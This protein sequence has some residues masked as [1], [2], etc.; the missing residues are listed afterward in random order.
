MMTKNSSST[1]IDVLDKYGKLISTTPLYKA[2]F[3]VKSGK[4]RWVN[5]HTIQIM[6]YKKDESRLKKQAWKRDNY[7]CYICGKQMHENHP[8]LTVDHITPRRN[9]GSIHLDNLGTC[10]RSCNQQK[11]WRD[12]DT[13]FKHLYLGITFMI[14][15]L[16]RQ[17]RLSSGIKSQE[18]EESHC[19]SKTS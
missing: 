3:S 15:W 18:K 17:G 11:G 4:S 2:E 1:K 5:P 19:D 12:F 13:Y 16:G 7:T 6:Y 9:G 14:L 10:C 8:E